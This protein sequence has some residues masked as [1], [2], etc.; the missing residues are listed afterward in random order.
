M[1]TWHPEWWLP[2][3]GVLG[4]LGLVAHEVINLS[5]GEGHQHGTGV[6]MQA[7]MWAAMIAI[8]LPLIAPNV[9]FIALRSPKHR[10]YQAT[11]EV[12]ASWAVAWIAAAV[13]LAFASSLAVRGLGKPIAITVFVVLAICWQ[14]SPLKLRST[15]RCHRTFAPPLD[16]RLASVAC[17]RFGARLGLD[18]VASCWA[19]M[20]VMAVAGHS[21]LAVGPLFWVSWA[22]RFRRPHHDPRTTT[23]VGVIAAAG[24]AAITVTAWTGP[25]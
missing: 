16:T 22:E 19:L 6:P 7:F 3:V 11:A 18:C 23:A 25:G 21:L 17:S 2:A 1:W 15:A 13:V 24:L 12:A 10:R 9:R 8:M 20:A 5:P 4:W 14:C